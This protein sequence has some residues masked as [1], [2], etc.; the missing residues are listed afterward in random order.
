MR[1]ASGM[2]LTASLCRGRRKKLDRHGQCAPNQKTTPRQKLANSF[3]S[4]VSPN[5]A[6]E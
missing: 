1:G 4:L 3:V 6:D 2:P 5:E